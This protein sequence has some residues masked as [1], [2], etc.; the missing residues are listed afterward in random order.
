MHRYAIFGGILRSE[1][2]LPELRP[3]PLAAATGGTSADW[4]LHV[5]PEPPPEPRAD[6]RLLGSEGVIPGVD[7][8]LYKNGASY[9]MT[10]E[11]TGAFDITPDGST[12]IWWKPDRA[13]VEAAQLDVVNRVLPV[14][15]HVSGL[16]CLHGSAVSLSGQAIAFLAPRHFGKSTLAIALTE[17]GGRI[18]TDDAVA[19]ELGPPLVARPGTHSV[20]LLDDAAQALVGDAAELRAVGAYPLI[21]RDAE[22]HADPAALI[23]KQVLR[24]LPNERLML[25]RAPLI[26]IYMLVP[27]TASDVDAVATRAP[28]SAGRAALSLVEHAKSG[29]LLGGPEAAV[30]FTRSVHAA[31]HV[32]IYQ[33]TLVRDF[34]RVAEVAATIAQWHNAGT[35]AAVA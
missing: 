11:D 24:E 15:L 26:A 5:A 21:R 9:R 33:L 29:A 27:S 34:E 31:R 23:T 17:I 7:V 12:I 22:Q 18:L 2:P 16:L 14:A 35:Q 1:I 8:R 13:R 19:V 25:E 4:T 28:L 6:A 3:P 32:P 10:Y 30:L 20:R